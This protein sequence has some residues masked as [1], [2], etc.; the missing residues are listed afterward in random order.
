MYYHVSGS[1]CDLPPPP[2]IILNFSIYLLLR[3]RGQSKA[4]MYL[5]G[6]LQVIITSDVVLREAAVVWRWRDRRIGTPGEECFTRNTP[7]FKK[8][9][10]Q[11]QNNT[12]IQIQ[13][14]SKEM[15]AGRLNDR[16]TL[17]R[18]S[19]VFDWI[20]NRPAFVAAPLLLPPFFSYSHVQQQQQQ[21]HRR[22]EEGKLLY[23][24]IGH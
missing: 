1:S 13:N 8:P 19:R 7:S 10:T 23:I 21:Q 22:S 12:K 18:C 24:F 5:E 11:K 9:E 20:W 15:N 16:G 2:G 3:E 17:G 4:L 6:I 14:R